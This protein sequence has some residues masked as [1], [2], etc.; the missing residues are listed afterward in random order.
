M[1]KIIT[2]CFKLL[3]LQFILF[4]QSFAQV[5]YTI[6]TVAGDGNL[7]FAGDG[8]PAT[9]ARFNGVSGIEVDAAGNIYLA[10]LLNN[11]IRK[12][13][14][15][16]GIIQTIAGTGVAG[17]SGDGGTALQAQIEPV[18]IALD[19]AGN[20]YFLD[21][22]VHRV[23]KIDATTQIVTTIAGTGVAGFSGDGGQATL[24]QLHKPHRLV[25]D[26][27]GNIYVADLKN[28]RIRKIDAHTGV[29][30]TIAG[31]GTLGYSG[32]GGDATQAQIHNI[33]AIELDGAGNVYLSGGDN[34]I[35]KVDAFT[36]NISLVAGNGIPGYGG[37]NGAATQ[38]QLAGPFGISVDPYGDVYIADYGNF[39]VRKVEACSGIITTV[40]GIGRVGAFEDGVSSL[41]TS[42]H[43]LR[44]FADQ[45]SNIYVQESARLRKLTPASGSNLNLRAN[46]LQ[47]AAGTTIKLP[48]RVQTKTDISGFQLQAE[49]PTSM[50]SFVKISDVNPKLLNFDASNY[51]EIEPGKVKVLWWGQVASYI[52]LTPGEVLFNIELSLPST[53]TLGDNFSIDFTN[54]AAVFGSKHAVYTHAQSGCVSIV[55]KRYSITGNIQTPNNDPVKDVLVTLTNNADNSNSTA[56]TNAAGVYSL[57]EVAPGNYTLTP[58]KNQGS[59]NNGL[60]IIDLIMIQRHILG[61]SLLDSPY[62]II[63]ADVDLSGTINI[64]DLA[65]VR[66]L[67]LEM[68][69]E[70]T[71]NWRFIPANYV[72]ADPANPLN[73]SFPESITIDVNNDVANQNFIAI[74][75]GDVSGDANPQLRT[76]SQPLLLSIPAQKAFVGEIIRVPV[77]VADNYRQIAA[78]QGTLEFD[79]QMLRYR[80]MSNGHLS[81][82][83]DHL[84]VSAVNQGSMAFVYNDPK[85]QAID[86]DNGKVLF[87]LNFEVI[88]KAQQSTAIRLTNQ[89]TQNQAYNGQTNRMQSLQ[90]QAGEIAIGEPQVSVF[91]NPAKRFQV[92]FG[93][94]KDQSQVSFSLRNQQG[95]VISRQQGIYGQGQ[96]QFNWQPNVAP[97]IYFLTIE[98]SQYKTTKKVVIK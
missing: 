21:R 64:V 15:A 57:G 82:T 2:F 73:T 71:K 61:Q 37:D 9:N 54:V 87:Y 59:L 25:A 60:N 90:L 78:L 18:D 41:N 30:S 69:T 43:P 6:S 38:A 74:K 67:I 72:F 51:N 63:A 5:S 85:G 50:A 95:Q 42:I 62:K 92:T 22:D 65:L 49:F 26:A 48:V 56:S 35:R 19:A 32:D 46:K 55:D 40:A 44:V 27:V 20:I 98:T 8:G 52:S 94:T 31:A 7:G 16:T 28:Y 24:A 81:L 80:G 91:P 12:I 13:D 93:I 66:S 77:T 53:L 23:R 39:R 79:P 68:D 34:R 76:T 96:Q 45:H 1:N 36:G 47:A 11:R 83:E 86:L 89:I 29:I 97:G 88:G 70:L 58:G 33:L 14:A 84:N 3:L 17:S 4:H 75:V 10:D